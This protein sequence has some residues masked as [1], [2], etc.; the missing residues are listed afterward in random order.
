MK[1]IC[2]QCG[3]SRWR[4]VEKNYRYKCRKCG[5]LK[6]DYERAKQFPSDEIFN[7]AI[8]SAK[9]QLSPTFKIEVEK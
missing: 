5:R 4:T 1:I 7:Q 2:P 8:D 9:F 3:A 6:T